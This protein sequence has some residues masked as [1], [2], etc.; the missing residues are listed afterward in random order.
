MFYLTWML[1]FTCQ[2]HDTLQFADQVAVW[3]YLYD[4]I[5]I[6]GNLLKFINVDPFSNANGNS[7]HPGSLEYVD[8]KV[9]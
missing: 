9:N 7:S 1:I 4:V 5:A 6:A 3:N 2:I 8:N